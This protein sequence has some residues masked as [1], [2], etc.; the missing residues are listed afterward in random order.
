MLSI[1]PNLEIVIVA[2]KRKEILTTKTLEDIEHRVFY[3][4]DYDLPVD[5]KSI[6]PTIVSPDFQLGSY[7]C[8]RG[9]QDAMRSCTK[10]YI[11]V[12]EDDAVVTNLASVKIKKMTKKLNREQFVSFI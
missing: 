2:N 3:T 9:H 11:M 10:D 5:F 7:R 1:L 4:T 8:F 6:D 12:F